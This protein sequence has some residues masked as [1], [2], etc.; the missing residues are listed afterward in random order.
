[1]PTREELG[2]AL[3]DSLQDVSALLDHAHIVALEEQDALVE[4]DAQEIASSCAA[5]EEI[6]RRVGEADMRAAAL[7]ENLAEMSGLDPNTTDNETIANSAGPIIGKQISTQLIVISKAA[8]RVQN[9]NEINSHLLRN[10]LDI[11][12]TCLRTVAPDNSPTI[13]SN[14]ANMRARAG[15]TLGLDSKA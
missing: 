4:N 1:M 7:A 15:T 5:Q 8:Q 9:A 11:I 14:D 3:L 10:G 2:N 13:Y 12:T 6:M